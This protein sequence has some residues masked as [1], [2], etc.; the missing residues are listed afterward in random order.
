MKDFL[1]AAFARTPYR[2]AR[3]A[4]GNRFSAIDDALLSMKARGY[5]PKSAIDGGANIGEF[6]RF[7]LELYSDAQVQAIESQ[8]G[9]LS[10]LNHLKAEFFDRLE[11]NRVALGNVEQD[12]SGLLFSSE[13]SGTSTGAHVS[14]HAMPD[15]STITVPCRSLDSLLD[16]SLEPTCC[17]LLK[18]DLQEYEMHALYEARSVL[19]SVEVVLC[20][21]SFFAQAYEPT[22]AKLIAYLDEHQ[23]DLYDVATLS[24]RARDDRPHQ[25]DLIFVRRS[26]QLFLDK[27]WGET[28]SL[29]R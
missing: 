28:F 21:V 4:P 6:S 26:S 22:I 16:T 13:P 12:G 15:S 7:A 19:R 1:K 20:E 8:Q 24:A 29:N 27:A 23:F 9:C 11:I 25:G 5:Y 2:V 18:L 17:A 3:R 14:P 10:Y